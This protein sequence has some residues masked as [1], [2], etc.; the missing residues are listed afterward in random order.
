MKSRLLRLHPLRLSRLPLLHPQR[1]DHLTG[2]FGTSEEPTWLAA[3]QVKK[4]STSFTES[5]LG[6]LEDSEINLIALS[7]IGRECEMTLFDPANLPESIL[8]GIRPLVSRTNVTDSKVYEPDLNI[9]LGCWL[10]SQ[11]PDFQS[12]L[13]AP[14]DARPPND[15]LIK[16]RAFALLSDL[17]RD[18]SQSVLQ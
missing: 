11:T 17:F 13:N 12:V 9:H 10:R 6:Q 15:M 8:Q 2:F 16:C 14:K 1:E 5:K 7:F 4:Q 3:G 18:P